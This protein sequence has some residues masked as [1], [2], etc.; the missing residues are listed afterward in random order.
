MKKKLVYSVMGLAALPIGVNAA[1]GQSTTFSTEKSQWSGA[2]S[3]QLE[4]NDLIISSNGTQVQYTIGNLQKGNYIF[5]GKLSSEIYNVTV[6]I[7]GQSQVYTG[8]DQ[9]VEIAFSLATE[10]QVTLT[11]TSAAKENAY[12]AGAEFTLGAPLL[13]LDY[14][15]EAA[16][17]T[18]LGIANPVKTK[19][20]A[21][22][23]RPPTAS[24]KPSTPHRRPIAPLSR[25]STSSWW[26][27]LISGFYGAYAAG[28][29]VEE[30][31][32]FLSGGKFWYTESGTAMK[33]L[34]AHFYFSDELQSYAAA[35]RMS[36][37]S[38]GT[39]GISDANHATTNYNIYH[40]LGGQSVEKPAKG[41]YI[42]NGKKVIIK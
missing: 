15:F 27:W 30:A 18:L 13:K 34:R 29:A 9:N 31:C 33:G 12:G 6:E 25:P 37:A 21:R 14:D 38:G 39:T 2:E 40:T 23:L 32:F 17:T 16:K 7:A 1:E 20:E 42:Q 28:S 22:T 35:A 3:A 41:L 24:T 26:A 19:I 36:I 8:I 11:M 4:A 10:T 5:R